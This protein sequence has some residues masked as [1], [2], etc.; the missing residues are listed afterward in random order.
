MSE[1]KNRPSL[2]DIIE[3]LHDS[4]INGSVLVSW[5]YYGASTVQLSGPWALLRELE[6]K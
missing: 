2:G 5:F 6:C 4:E 3:A 1:T